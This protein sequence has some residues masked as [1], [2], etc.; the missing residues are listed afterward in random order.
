MFRLDNKIALVTGA[1]SGIGREIALLYARQG[2]AVVVADINMEAAGKVV[3]EITQAGGS[4]ASQKMNVAD[5]G[6]V[7]ATICLLYTLT[8][9]TT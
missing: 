2:A 8:L 5:E 9:P 7:Q 6:E 3:E 4:A 1:G